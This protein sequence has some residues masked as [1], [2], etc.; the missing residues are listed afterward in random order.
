MNGPLFFYFDFVLFPILA[1]VLILSGEQ[2]SYF[3]GQVIGGAVLFTFAEYWAHRS[4]LH[5]LFYH[6]QHEHHHLHPADYVVFPIWYTPLIFFLFW[7]VFPLGIFTGLVIGYCWFLTWHHVLHHFDL[8]QWP[9][10]KKYA[11]WHLAHHHNPKCNYGITVPIWDLLFRTY[12][13]G[14]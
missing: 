12:R 2:T 10:V 6:G 4:F 11:L 13:K 1:I 14:I 3:W 8:T 5:G 7:F 9:L